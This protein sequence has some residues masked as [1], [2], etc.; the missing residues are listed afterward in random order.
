MPVPEPTTAA[1]TLPEDHVPPAVP[2]LNVV[3]EPTHTYGAPPV[4]AAGEVFTVTANVL[5]QPVPAV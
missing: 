2:S 1:A 4:I 3:V 5:T